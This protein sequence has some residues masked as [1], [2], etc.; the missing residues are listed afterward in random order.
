MANEK[1]LIIDD[2]AYI[3]NACS[4]FLRSQGYAVSVAGTGEK[5]VELLNGSSFELVITDYKMPGMD[6]LEVLKYVK[7]NYPK[8][9]VI[10]ITAYGTIENAVKA[11]SQGAY[12]YLAKNFTLDE[13][14]I[15]VKR[16]LEKQQLAV[17]V[18]ELKE[19][20]NLYEVSKAI[21][22]LMGLDDLL[23]LILKLLSDTLSADS[24]SIMLYNPETRELKVRVAIGPQKDF[25][26]GKRILLGSDYGTEQ[27]IT[28]NDQRFTVVTN[29]PDIRSTLTLHLS[30]KNTLFGVIHLER[31][32]DAKFTRRDEYLLS[33][34]AAEAG[35][36]IENAYLYNS[37][38]KEKEEL[39]AIFVNMADGSIAMDTSFGI[40]RMNHAAEVLL[41]IDSKNNIGKNLIELLVDFR[42]SV[43]W[44]VF[45]KNTDQII[46]FEL[47]RTKGKAIYL[48]VVATRIFD[49][50]NNP[51][52][53]IWVLRDI[54]EEKKEEKHKNDFL[55][56]ITHK[57]KTPLTSIIGYTSI[58]VDR[59]KNPE[60]RTLVALNTIRSQGDLLDELVDSLIEFTLI[61]SEFIQLN[62]ETVSLKS[63]LSI[64]RSNFSKVVNNVKAEL[65]IDEN[66]GQVPPLCIDR[67]KIIVVLENLIR[68]AVRF[69]DKAE[70]EVHISAET[71]DEKFITVNIK[72]NGNGM[73]AKEYE[74]VFKKFYQIDEYATGQI[75]GMGL[76]LA[77]VKRIIEIHGCKAWVKSSS[78]GEGSTFAVTLPR[79]QESR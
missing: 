68:N 2:D 47:K 26:I 74:N 32:K 55:A 77:L 48:G 8:T 39:N 11:M 46:Q 75:K 43:L 60:D 9:D 10:I 51:V 40:S 34:F 72:D 73:P 23:N 65:I 15:V 76:G 61:D 21:N 57:F 12:D 45:A 62:L 1:I 7:K 14:E 66:T 37:L 38:E 22:S 79:R 64:C 70:K 69:N 78:V 29:S 18:S 42:P 4:D 25:L 3:Q 24:G 54:T 53:F 58:L 56:L 20:V 35:V 44:D 67:E 31:T 59:L 17:Q 50:E 36:A 33:I 49:K 27:G 28:S 16:C 71:T 5:G 6:G 30:R 63:V 41:G 13:L 52:G 19:V